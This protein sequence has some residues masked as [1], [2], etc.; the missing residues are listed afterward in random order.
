VIILLEAHV[1]GLVSVH[2]IRCLG[3]HPAVGNQVRG[4]KGRVLSDYGRYGLLLLRVGGHLEG[5]LD[6]FWT[7]LG[8]DLLFCAGHA[9][10]L[11]GSNHGLSGHGLVKSRRL[12]G[13]VLQH[14]RLLLAIEHTLR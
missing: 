1:L 12:N 3:T 13:E 9:L 5:L 7:Q 14:D 4:D 6:V 8:L 10:I 11:E 2:F